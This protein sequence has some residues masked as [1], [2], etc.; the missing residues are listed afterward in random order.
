[1]TLDDALK[2]NRGIGPGFHMLRH[3]LS[4]VILLHHCRVAVFGLAVGDTYEKGVALTGAAASHL[5]RGQSV[6]ELLRPGLYALA[7]MF[8]ALSGFLV[9]ASAIR[10]SSIKV[11]FG[12]RFLRIAPALTIEVTLSALVF[13][14]FFTSFSLDQY[15]SDYHFFRYFGN[16]VGHVTFELPGVFLNNPWPRMIN[17]NLWTLPAEFWCYLFMLIMMATGVLLHRKRLTIAIFASAVVAIGLAF[18]DPALFSI[19]QDTTHFTEWYIV[20]MFFFGVLFYINASRILLSRWLFLGAAAGY[21][22]LTLMDQLGALSGLLLTYCMVYIGMQSFPWFDRLL[23][24]DLS[25]GIYLYGFPIT[26]AIVYLAL[27]HMG[28]APRIL[29]F[30]VIFPLVL[31]LTGVFSTLSWDYIEKPALSLRKHI[32]REPRPKVVGA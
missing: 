30:L 29:C 11:F 12:N 24:R 27:P 3:L 16:I 8:F 9:V 17:A 14:P 21:Y 25:Y 18:Y 26:Q 22:T 15:F 23:K 20:M 7:G 1:M 13:G 4:I 28:G 6:V 19:R 2:A 32:L 10:N 31:V 5:T